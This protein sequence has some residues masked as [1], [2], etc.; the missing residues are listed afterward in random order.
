MGLFKKGM[1]CYKERRGG[2]RKRKSVR[3]C[4]VGHDL[5]ILSCV[6]VK[7]GEQ[8]IPD[9]TDSD[10]PKRLGPKRASK[11]RKL[12][13]LEAEDDVKKYVVRREVKEGSKKTKA[14]KI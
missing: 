13:N 4:I 1:G 2:M 14:P 10:K 5:A 6:I 9:L 8:D 3:G 7:K 11:I 12:F